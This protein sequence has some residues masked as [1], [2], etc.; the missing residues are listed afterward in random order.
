[1]F[2]SLFI[3]VSYLH[4]NRQPQPFL[5]LKPLVLM[6][7]THKH[8]ANAAAPLIYHVFNV[9]QDQVIGDN[10]FDIRA[11]NSE[12][13]EK[14]KASQSHELSREC[15]M[16]P[17]GCLL[18]FFPQYSQSILNMSLAAMRTLF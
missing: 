7:F 8:I 1:M 9:E 12:D 2:L 5:P 15:S 16:A 11:G 17:T 6:A 18:S 13:R 3:K 10:K 14:T 4:R